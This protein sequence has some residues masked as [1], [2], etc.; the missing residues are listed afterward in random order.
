MICS[1]CR[2][3]VFEA[4]LFAA[5]DEEC[6]RPLC[7]ECSNALARWRPASVAALDIADPPF[8]LQRQAS[9]KRYWCDRG[10][11]PTAADAWASVKFIGRY[12][13]IRIQTRERTAT[14]QTTIKWE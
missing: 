8:T 1:E 10:D 3:E 2:L 4:P 5:D 11:F 12:R 7:R 9:D 13:V 14:E 6:K